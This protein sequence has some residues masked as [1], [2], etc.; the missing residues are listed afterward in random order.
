VEKLAHNVLNEAKVSMGL[1]RHSKLGRPQIAMAH[2]GQE[3][4]AACLSSFHSLCPIGQLLCV[5]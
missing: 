5:I 3:V 1:N 2:R 4:G